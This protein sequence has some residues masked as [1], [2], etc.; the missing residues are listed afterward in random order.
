[1]RILS[2]DPGLTLVW[3]R[4]RRKRIKR[5]KKEIRGESVEDYEGAWV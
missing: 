2:C 1:V 5:V 4:R 3:L